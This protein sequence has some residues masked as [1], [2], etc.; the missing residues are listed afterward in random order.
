MNPGDADQRRPGRKPGTPSTCSVCGVIGHTKL[1]HV[2]G[3][4]E[5]RSVRA[6]RDVDAE[7]ITLEEAGKRYGIT[8]EAVRLGWVKLFGDRPTAGREQAVSAK[9]RVI[10]GAVRGLSR[11]QI[12][13]ETGLSMSS[14]GRF[15]NERGLDA[16]REIKINDDKLHRAAGM[17]RTGSSY[18]EAAAELGVSVGRLSDRLRS[19]GVRSTA[20]NGDRMD[21]RIA[22]AVARVQTGET[23]PEASRN[24]KCASVGVYMALRKAG[25]R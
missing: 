23:V 3:A 17:V 18:A 15:L 4:A 22:R 10:I 19:I 6:A 7:L 11:K 8:R 13:E 25:L 2:E 1:S 14:V 12:V 9:R 24:E 21:G 16:K 5:S 20:N